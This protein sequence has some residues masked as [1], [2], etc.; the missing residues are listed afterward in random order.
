MILLLAP[1]SE[2]HDGAIRVKS[3]VTQLQK[4]NARLSF[5]T[6]RDLWMKARPI[7]P[8]GITWSQWRAQETG[9][10]YLWTVNYQKL[11]GEHKNVIV[12]TREDGTI[13][14]GTYRD[15]KFLKKA[16]ARISVVLDN[17]MHPLSRTSWDHTKDENVN[18]ARFSIRP[19]AVRI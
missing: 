11:M 14:R 7:K 6:S 5:I 19:Q 2:Y 8:P 4:K 3:L 17:G 1:V 16:G 12:L 15:I 18:A 10:Y 13:G 9:F